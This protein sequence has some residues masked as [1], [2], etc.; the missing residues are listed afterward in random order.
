[1]NW[2][3]ECPYCRELL[4]SRKALRGHVGRVH[5]EKVDDFMVRYR[6]GRTIPPRGIK[7]LQVVRGKPYHTLESPRVGVTSSSVKSPTQTVHALC[8]AGCRKT[9]LTFGRTFILA[10]LAGVYIGFG[11]QLSTTVTMDLAPKLG[12]GLSNLIGGAVFSVGLML[13]VLCGAE[14]FTGNNLMILAYYRGDI[15]LR[16]LL[17]SWF[18]VYVGNFVGSILLVSIIFGGALYTLGGGALGLRAL[19][20]ANSKVTSTFIQLLCRG[21]ACNWLVC[22]A[23]WLA[24]SSDDSVF[25]VLA[26]LFPIMSFVASGFEHS[27][28]NMYFIPIGLLMKQ[29]PSLAARSGLDLTD[30]TWSG[31]VLRNLLPVTIGN[32]IGGA[33]FVAT[34]HWF[35]Y[36]RPTEK[37]IGSVEP[38]SAAS[39]RKRGGMFKKLYQKLIEYVESVC[40]E[41]ETMCHENTARSRLA[42]NIAENDGRI[43]EHLVKKECKI[44]GWEE[45]NDDKSGA[46]SEYPKVAE[47]PKPRGI[48]TESVGEP[49]KS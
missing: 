4:P 27:V 18:A 43:L 7:E 32:I 44:R 34:T 31:L 17:K 49:A 15:T 37:A 6:G 33:F 39:A 3:Y 30:L 19:A 9:L 29:I 22:L 8:E 12:V 26:C 36:I 21:I 25:K 13:V 11:A 38:I 10:I 28:A 24:S 16:D 42:L 20:I 1:M 35:T 40:D 41:A 23:V 14:L 47:G 46:R 2:Y 48:S 45:P 5:R